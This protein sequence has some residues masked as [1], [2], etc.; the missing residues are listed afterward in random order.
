ME[1]YKPWNRVLNKG[2]LCKMNNVWPEPSNTQLQ[3]NIWTGVHFRSQAGISL[4][5]LSGPAERVYIYTKWQERGPS[6]IFD[7]GFRSL[8]T[9]AKIRM[10][11]CILDLLSHLNNPSNTL[12]QNVSSDLPSN[13]WIPQSQKSDKNVKSNLCRNVATSA[14]WHKYRN[15]L[16]PQ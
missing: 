16:Q 12:L 13:N 15:Q 8:K 3:K 2:I 10:A 6:E 5:R 4:L 14:S 7:W 1:K 11:E 9:A